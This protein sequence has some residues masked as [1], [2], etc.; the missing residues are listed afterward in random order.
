MNNVDKIEI[1]LEELAQE[2]KNAGGAIMAVAIVSRSDKE[3]TIIG[4]SYGNAARIAA[5][6][7]E[8]EKESE[9]LQEI[10]NCYS[11]ITTKLKINKK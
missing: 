11:I 4:R 9:H 7:L 6:I 8:S 10:R 5:S 3:S 1:L 2:V